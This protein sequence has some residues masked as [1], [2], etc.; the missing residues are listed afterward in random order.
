FNNGMVVTFAML[1]GYYTDLYGSNQVQQMP[2]SLTYNGMT[3][4][5]SAIITPGNV[6]IDFVNS[7]NFYTAGVSDAQ[8][9]RCVIVPGG[10]SIPDN[11]KGPA[12]LRYLR[13]P[14]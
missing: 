13:V 6:R 9:F 2:V 1:N 7:Q 11:L 14:N 8:E 12:L 10:V 4:T 3:D 5:W